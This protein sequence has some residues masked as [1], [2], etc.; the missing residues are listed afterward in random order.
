MFIGHA[1]RHLGNRKYIV[2]GG[3]QGT[4]HGSSAALVGD[5]LQFSS[6]RDDRRVRQQNDLLVRNGTRAV[7]DCRPNVLWGEVWIVFD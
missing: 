4:D 3:A 6:L 1:L 5:E 7:S 2:D